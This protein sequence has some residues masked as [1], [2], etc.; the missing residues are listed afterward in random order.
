MPVLREPGFA[1]LGIINIKPPS[2]NINSASNI[3]CLVSIIH[4]G[5][6]LFGFML[7][8]IPAL[9]QPSAAGQ[10]LLCSALL[11]PS[12]PRELIVFGFINKAGWLELINYPALLHAGQGTRITKTL[13]F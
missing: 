10:E 4:S 9:M 7:A 11:Q 12:G 13:R 5:A 6:Q 8:S 3:L 1:V 2:G